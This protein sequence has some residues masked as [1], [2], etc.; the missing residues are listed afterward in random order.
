MVTGREDE[1]RI[2]SGLKQRKAELAGKEI[3]IFG[4]TPYAKTIQAILSKW[5]IQVTAIIDN[6]PDKVGKDCMG[7]RHGMMNN[8]L[9]IIICF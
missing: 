2:C 3:V 8:L 6:H 9:H 4:C 7:R 1:I 5:M